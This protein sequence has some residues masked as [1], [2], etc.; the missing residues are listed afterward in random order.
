MQRQLLCCSRSQAQKHDIVACAAVQSKL[1]IRSRAASKLAGVP[2]R[3]G[4]FP[5]PGTGMA[6]IRQAS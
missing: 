1:R 6:G 2:V 3:M 5:T 4:T